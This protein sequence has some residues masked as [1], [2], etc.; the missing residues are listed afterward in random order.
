MPN[1]NIDN[2]PIL[3]GFTRRQSF[4]IFQM[5][6]PLMDV[7]CEC[8]EETYMAAVKLTTLTK[9]LEYHK[10]R[11]DFMTE[12]PDQLYV[13]SNDHLSKTL[14][15]VMQEIMDKAYPVDDPVKR[16]P[17]KMLWIMNQLI[18]EKHNDKPIFVEDYP[19][20]GDAVTYF[21]KLRQNRDLQPPL[22]LRDL[23]DFNSIHDLYET[24]RPYELR[25][26][27]KEIERAKRRMTDDEKDNIFRQTSVLYDGEEG[28]VVIPHTIA[29]SQYW[30][31]HTKWCLSGQKTAPHDFPRYNRTQPIIM[32]LPA[33]DATGNEKVSLVDRRFWNAQ[34]KSSNQT[35]PIAYK[36]LF[37]A[38]R[39]S[40][41]EAKHYL[42][43]LLPEKDDIGSATFGPTHE[44]F[45]VDKDKLDQMITYQK[46][47]RFLK[48]GFKPKPPKDDF[49]NLDLLAATFKQDHTIETSDIEIDESLL[50]D[51]QTALSLMRGMGGHYEIF[52]DHIRHDRD[53]LMASFQSSIRS[54][55]HTSDELRN[56]RDIAK[57]AV[58]VNY[59]ALAYLPAFQDDEEIVFSHYSAFQ[60]ASERIKKDP[61][62]VK[63]AIELEPHNIAHASEPIKKD[64]EIIKFAI[65]H[66]PKSIFKVHESALLNDDLLKYAIK[67]GLRI[68]DAVNIINNK[69]RPDHE[70]LLQKLQSEEFML[71]ALKENAFALEGSM[72][73]LTNQ[74]DFVEKALAQTP[75]Y[76]LSKPS[77]FISPSPSPD[78]RYKDAFADNY[79]EKTLTALKIK[80]LESLSKKAGA[81]ATSQFYQSTRDL[82]LLWGDAQTLYGDKKDIIEAVKKRFER[83]YGVSYDAA[84]NGD[85]SKHKKP[86]SHNK[87][88]S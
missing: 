82:P 87:P 65:E 71:E 35:T 42:S 31:N 46:C 63:K 39:E 4:V 2:A 1:N 5:A 36:L 56:D 51:K 26:Q 30:G 67:N 40:A 77:S 59:N 16:D 18:H 70:L 85:G 25:K 81:T 23:T 7:I 58:G 80:G 88:S 10:D 22:P 43:H 61:E 72:N 19:K 45:N 53:V 62:L 9:I 54:L 55:Q 86:S 37:S 41:P 52:P 57:M 64:P 60:H 8:D 13:P 66:D 17:G 44:R 83:K 50:N 27:A 74:K 11:Q 28:R 6:A 29:A 84:L 68:H 38:F 73:I 48:A 49:K 20:V 34:D 47:S 21:E 15:P 78:G 24:L 69:K 14:A 33:K 76:I 12:N 75:E 32:I 3:E 79:D